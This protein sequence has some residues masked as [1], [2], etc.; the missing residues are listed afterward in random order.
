MTAIS[1][2]PGQGRSPQAAP[3]RPESPLENALEGAAAA[4]CALIAMVAVSALA[5]WLL[6][7]ESLGSLWS[8]ALTVTAMAVGG[9]VS[10]AAASSG[11]EGSGGLSG[12]LGGGGLSPTMS[13]T[14]D[15]LPFGVTLLGAMVLWLAFSWRMRRR[16]F[17][18]GEL[19]GRT[20][21]AAVTALLGFLTVAELAEGSFRMP[22]S[23]MSG[24]RGEDSTSGGLGIGN[25]PLGELFGGGLGRRLGGGSAMSRD[26]VMNYQVQAGSAVLGGLLW[27]AVVIALGCLITRRA[28]LPLPWQTGRLRAAWAPS[29][30]AVARML[31]LM[32]VV[33]LIA[34]VFIGIVV[35]GKGATAAGAAL[36][37]APDAVV[38]FVTLGLGVSWTASTHQAQSEDGNPLAS[39]LR[40]LGGAQAQAR[41][42]RVEHLRDLSAGGWPLW[43]LALLVTGLALLACGY[44][45]ARAT[46]R[47]LAHAPSVRRTRHGQHLAPAARLGVVLGVALGLTAW[48]TQASGQISATMFGSEM[49]GTQAGLS[50]SVPLA[51]LLGLLAGAAAGFVG[52]VLHGLHGGQTPRF[53]TIPRNTPVAPVGEHLAGAPGATAHG[54]GSA[55]LESSLGN[56]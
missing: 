14:V 25:S 21:G 20:A 46:A 32:T 8:L 5:L 42:D 51:A 15:A 36:L 53:R 29:V 31:L 52:S 24:M 18:A 44:A 16:P 22:A 13:G 45:A 47:T 48:L 4:L 27:V 11:A 33:P 50:G 43:L 19:A 26:M 34:V 1:V 6:D 23:A 39:L 28:H 30:S 3:D 56:R 12:L 37:L 2:E 49:G 55:P 9:S 10:P 54:G 41:P 38:V 7:A 40:R 17:T 35:G